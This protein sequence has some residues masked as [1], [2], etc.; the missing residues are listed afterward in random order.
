MKE[1]HLQTCNRLILLLFM[2][3]FVAV[4]AGNIGEVMKGHK[5]IPVTIGFSVLAATIFAFLNYFYLKEKETLMIKKYGFI[6]FFLVYTYTLFATSR[7]LV[8]IYVY[9][10]LFMF[11][12]YYDPKQMRRIACSILGLNIMRV[13][14]LILF[15]GLSDNNMISDYT[16]LIAG[17]AVICWGSALS[18]RMTTEYNNGTLE[19]IQTAHDKQNAILTEVLSIGNSLDTYSNDMYSI[20][21]ELEKSTNAMNTTMV[22]MENSFHQASDSIEKQTSLTTEIQSEIDNTSTAAKIME[23]TSVNIRNRM[24]EGMNIVNNLSNN[25][26]II[27]NNGSIVYTSMNDLKEKAAVIGKITDTIS[28]IANKT[29]ILSLN[30]S[31]ESARAGEAGK[32]FAVVAKEVGDLAAQTTQ[33]V[34]E[35][36]AIIDDLQNMVS[37]TV[38]AVEDFQ[39]A[40]NEQDSLIHHTESIFKETSEYMQEVNKKATEVS[41]KIESI[42]SS[43]QEIMDNINIISDTSTTA[44]NGIQYT[45]EVTN[46]NRVQVE[47]TKQIGNQLLESSSR[48][49]NYL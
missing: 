2:V 49:K 11:T 8:S 7:L 30:A 3:I 39:T 37:N 20:V 29:N 48:L 24:M 13:I 27:T 31:I 45:L 26:S 4:T 21:S 47:E 43:N 6:L 5:S 19:T 38:N 14:W 9:P 15:W 44:L 17:T 46:N 28:T 23:Q 22:E 36:S 16:I 41:D 35:I 1:K 32:G 10:V 42:L 25:A 40:N 33:S 12:M 34:V 18:T